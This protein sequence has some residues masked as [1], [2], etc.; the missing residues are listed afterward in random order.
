MAR[1]LGVDLGSRRIGLAVSD[2]RRATA[3]PLRVLTRCGDKAADH[4]EILAAARDHDATAI[5]VGLPLTLGGE[6]GPA[7]RKVLSEVDLLRTL[8]GDEVTVE[9]HDERLSTRTAEAAMLE[10]GARRA[11][12][13][14]RVDQ[15]AAAV[16]LQSWLDAHRSPA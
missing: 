12:R 2:P 10:G 6:L 13:R 1:V 7:A 3:S 9:V 14:E 4:E 5:V 15:V 16:I 11:H 8:A